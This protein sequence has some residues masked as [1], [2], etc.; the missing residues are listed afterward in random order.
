MAVSSQSTDASQKLVAPLRRLGWISFWLQVVLGVVPLVIFIFGRLFN[1]ASGEGFN[2]TGLLT[3]V[4]LIGLLFTIYWSFQYVRIAKAIKN[5][6]RHPTKSGV[7]RSLWLGTSVNLGVMALA[8]VIGMGMLGTMIGVMMV[9]PQG[10]AAVYQTTPNG[11]AIVNS[12]YAIS[13]MD[14]FGLQAVINAIAA[15]LVGTVTSLLLIRRLN[16]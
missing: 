9:L 7:A 16:A 10:A 14:L 3:L 1:P 15:G 13:T 6:R 5:P 12:R 2:L 4:C 11:S 8:L